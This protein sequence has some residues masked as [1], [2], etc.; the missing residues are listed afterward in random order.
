MCWRQA[1]KERP[2]LI[3]VL[4]CLEEESE[5]TRDEMQTEVDVDYDDDTDS[6]SEEQSSSSV[7]EG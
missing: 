2:N 4:E 7:D 5:I 6:D 3:H 1:A